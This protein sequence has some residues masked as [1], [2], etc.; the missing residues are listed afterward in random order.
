MP[1]S[2]SVIAITA[3]LLLAGCQAAATP[4][5]APASP[6]SAPPSITDT[7]TVSPTPASTPSGTWIRLTPDNGAP[8]TPIQIDGYLPGGPTADEAQGNLTLQH[9]TVCWDGCLTG[10]TAVDV[11]VQWSADQAGNFTIN[12]NA[13]S[14]PWW[15]SQGP[16]PVQDGE[17]AVGVQCLGPLVPGCANQEAL[18][19]ASFQVVGAQPS[20][21]GQ[22][23]PCAELTLNPSQAQPGDSVQVSGWAPLIETISGEPFGYT[24]AIRAGDANTSTG[25]I[26]QVTQQLNGG[27]DRGLHGAPIH[28]RRWHAFARDVRR[29][30]SGVSAPDDRH[31]PGWANGCQGQ[32]R[33]GAIPGMELAWCRLAHLAVADGRPRQPVD[34]P[35]S[36]G[37]PSAGLLRA[38]RHPTI[39][40]IRGNRG[41]M[42]P[43]SGPS[44]PS[45]RSGSR[46]CRAGPPA[47][48][49]SVFPSHSTPPIPTAFTLYSP[50][51]NGR[52]APRPSSSKG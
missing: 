16:Q 37:R 45:I 48:R 24:L 44:M 43:S 1:S 5:A 14:V 31:R 21:C 52:W 10:F 49:H 18:A 28:P 7:P 35:R 17:Y 41:E 22:A 19:T 29:I 42:Y 40:A 50:Q 2:R 15:G 39:E 46:S 6:T 47:A 12:F 20:R 3:S 8:G 34:Q 13:P 38:K 32:S 23:Q 9:T 51:P 11:P 25:P 30:A 33:P 4:V 26:G 27:L 36:R